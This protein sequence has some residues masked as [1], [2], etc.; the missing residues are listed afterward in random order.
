MIT[1][2][3]LLASRQ[4]SIYLILICLVISSAMMNPGITT[5]MFAVPVNAALMFLLRW[6]AHSEGRAVSKQDSV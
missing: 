2:K 3:Q 5:L 1:L 6:V 4:L